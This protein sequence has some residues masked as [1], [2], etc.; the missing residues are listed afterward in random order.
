MNADESKGETPSRA[1]LDVVSAGSDF[2]GASVG[3]VVGL[4]GGPGG[5]VAGA[6]AGVAVTRALR[7]VGNQLAAQIMGERRTVRMGAAFVVAADEIRRRLAG[8]ERP[9]ADGFFESDD[10]SRPAGEELLEGV[11]L[12]ASDTYQERKAKYLGY[13]YANV[14]FDSTAS[15]AEANF[16]LSVADRLTY[17]G[18]VL[19]ALFDLGWTNEIARAEHKRPADVRPGETANADLLGEMNDLGNYGL[20]G[21]RQKEGFVATYQSVLDGGDFTRLPLTQIRQTAVGERLYELLGLENI[22]S[23]DIREVVEELRHW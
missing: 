22:P 15:P 17:R 8:G 21:L 3:G 5:V 14:A 13:L 18:F 4:I 23:S 9:R 20:L 2:A 6:A 16:L 7:H 12:R 19:L 1:L 11:L 10:E